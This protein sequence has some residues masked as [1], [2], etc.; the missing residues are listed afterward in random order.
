MA[1]AADAEDAAVAWAE[2]PDEDDEP[3]AAGSEAGPGPSA[4][5]AALAT[6]KVRES[7]Y[8][9]SSWG[10]NRR[11]APVPTKSPRDDKRSIHCHAFVERSGLLQRS[12]TAACVG[13]LPLKPPAP[14]I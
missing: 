3:A 5:S 12:C 10:V 9:L 6:A 1:A 2:A 13:A 14:S 8:Q 7:S 11:P 4:Q